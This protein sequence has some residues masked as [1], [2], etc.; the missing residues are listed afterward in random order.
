MVTVS[1]VT[2]CRDNPAELASTL[3][4]FSG[5]DAALTEVVVIDGSTGEDCE[6]IACA[7]NGVTAYK[8]GTD[9][10]KY[11]AMNKGLDVARGDGVI[12]INSGDRLVSGPSFNQ[13]VSGNRDA[14]KDHIVYGDNLLAI[15]GKLLPRTAPIVDAE[16][17]RIGLFP[18]HQAIIIPASFYRSVRYDQTLQISADTKL[19]RQ[20]FGTL[21]FIKVDEPIAVFS[22]GGISSMPGSWPSVLNHYREMIVARDLRPIEKFYLAR[23]LTTRKLLS[24]LLTPRGL[25]GLQTMMAVRRTKTQ[26]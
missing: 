11:N 4:S 18:S 22:H 25:L 6:R 7:S 16:H 26:P 8:R 21:P 17:I 15:G 1:I 19:L 2:I 5:L 13:I 3:D 12:F 9:T 24:V 14:I 10:G 23:G 20:A